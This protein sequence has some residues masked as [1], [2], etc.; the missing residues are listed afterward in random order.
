AISSKPNPSNAQ[1]QVVTEAAWQQRQDNQVRALLGYLL[2]CPNR[3]AHRLALQAA[4]WPAGDDETSVR[5]MNKT[6]QSLQRILSYGS[7][8]RSHAFVEAEDQAAGVSVQPLRFD[9]DWL[10]L[11]GQEYVWVD[12]D[13]FEEMLQT[14]VDSI[15]S[16][17]GVSSP[18]ISP[19]S[20]Q[21][22]PGDQQMV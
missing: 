22:I 8:G 15:V 2:C 7:G 4:L 21:E 13:V 16:L 10:I 9:G 18:K 6:I 3:R 19:G 20:T 17:G 12:A 5:R 1:W 14:G 11:A